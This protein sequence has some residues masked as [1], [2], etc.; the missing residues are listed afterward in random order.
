[1]TSVVDPW[2]WHPHPDVWL[3]MFGLIAGYIVSVVHLGP[4]LAGPGEL[5]ATQK[6]KAFFF[7]GIFTLWLAA[8]WPIHDLAEDYLFSVHMVQHTIF[9]LISAPLLI[10]GIPRW[11]WRQVLSVRW[12]SAPLRVLTRPLVALI[13]FNAVVLVT[14]W[15][16][17]VNASVQSEPIHFVVHVIVVASA[18]IMWLPVIAP[19]PEFGRLSEPGKMLYLF[20]QSILP[21]VPASFLTFADGVI[22]S[23]YETAPRIWGLDAVTDQ[24]ISGLIMKLGGGLLLWS[25]ITLLFFRWNAKEE[26]QPHEEVAWDDFERELDNWNL[27]R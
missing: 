20:L 15:P 9:T 5:P 3:L 22:Y 4:R 12:I 6:E 17:I 1:L 23:F 26:K 13:V 18:A 16:T 8:D 24:R 7:A 25:V 27:R 19:A 10:L 21:T 11:M 2:A 14:H